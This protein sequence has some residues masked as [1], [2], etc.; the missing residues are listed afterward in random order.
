MPADRLL[1][2]DGTVIDTEPEPHA[3]HA[4]DVLIEDGRIAAV[5]PGLPSAGA[6]VLDCSGHIV[7]PGFVDAH[8]HLWQTVLRGIAPDAGLMDYV[9]L[10]QRR[11]AR[12]LTPEDVHAATLAGA[13]EC[14]DGGITTVQDYSDIQRSPGHTEA[15]LSALREAGVRAVFGYGYPLFGPGGGRPAVRDP[16]EVRRV[17]AEHFPGDGSLLRMV[18]APRGPSYSPMD[19]VRE[20]WLLARE[21]GLRIA[22]HVASGPLADH[23]VAALRDHDLLAPGTLYVHGNSLPGHE[24]LL[25]AGSGGSVSIAPAVEAQMGHGPPMITRLREAKVTTA[26]GADVVT[27][28]PGDMFSLMRAALLTARLEHP[29]DR[30]WRPSGEPGREGEAA[31]RLT[32]S[33]V[34]RM[35]TL[36]GAVALGLDDQVGSLRVGKQADLLLI[37]T[38]VVNLSGARHDPVGTVVTAA[39]PG[40]VDTV[41]V[42]G[43]PVKYAG[44]LVTPAAPAAVTATHRSAGRLAET[45]RASA[46]GPGRS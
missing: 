20:D 13:L 17:R 45:L 3:R 19:T 38:G 28:S 43:E 4:V 30:T 18:L 21:L 10:V 5:G 29:V 39:H 16:A 15:A 35:A 2:R 7:L 46:P 24:L 23:P 26:L 1:L 27:S 41:L 44:R 32:T 11:L 34:L 40:N 36:D 33:D 37:R 14:L 6:T 9:S 22:V 12:R 8:R 42:A 31:P 25:I